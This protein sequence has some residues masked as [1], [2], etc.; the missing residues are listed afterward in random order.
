MCVCTAHMLHIKNWI[1]I[2]F[3]AD[4]SHNDLNTE[5]SNSQRI[6]N[7]RTSLERQVI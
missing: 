1:I 5:R 2:S 7:Q 4:Q 6:E 3:Q